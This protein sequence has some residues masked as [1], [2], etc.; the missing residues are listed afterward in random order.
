MGLSFLRSVEGGTDPAISV[1][2]MDFLRGATIL[3]GSGSRLVWPIMV[4]GTF[5]TCVDLAASMCDG[6]ARLP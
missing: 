6:M 4:L 2:G 1:S 5:R 3:I